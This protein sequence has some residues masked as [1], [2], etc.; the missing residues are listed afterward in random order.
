MKLTNFSPDST[1]WSKIPACVHA[2]ASGTAT[3]RKRQVGELQLRVVEYSAGYVADHWCSKGHVIF[4]VAGDFTIEH[5]D[6]RSFML[7][8]GMSYHVADDDRAAHR[9]RSDHGAT[10]FVVD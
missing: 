10:I 4:V 2:G 1:D 7:T 5:Q 8:A 6:G 3:E 9:A